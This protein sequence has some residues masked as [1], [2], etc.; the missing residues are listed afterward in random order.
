MGGGEHQQ[1]WR[2]RQKGE[3]IDDGSDFL[4]FIWLIGKFFLAW[5]FSFYFFFLPAE[6]LN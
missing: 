2:I 5:N 6:E 1:R 3:K 4:F